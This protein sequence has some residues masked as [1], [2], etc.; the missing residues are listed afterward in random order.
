MHFELVFGNKFLLLFA[1]VV[2]IFRFFDCDLC[3]LLVEIGAQ[4]ELALI[5]IDYIGSCIDVLCFKGLYFAKILV[6]LIQRV[7]F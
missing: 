3:V 6:C 7:L 2:Y 5:V 1:H 4:A